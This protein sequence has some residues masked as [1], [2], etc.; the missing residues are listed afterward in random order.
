MNLHFFFIGHDAPLDFH[1]LLQVGQLAL[2]VG[3]FRPVDLQ[4]RVL[5]K[6]GLQLDLRLRI[7]IALRL[8]H[9]VVEGARAYHRRH[10]KA[11]NR[12]APDSS[13]RF[14]VGS[15]FTTSPFRRSA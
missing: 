1:L 8:E 12:F 14:I 10:T 4:F 3:Q 9:R 11:P 2:H 7:L 15:A 13:P 6:F 5:A